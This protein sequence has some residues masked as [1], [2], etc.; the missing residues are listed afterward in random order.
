MGNVL[1]DF[2]TYPTILRLLAE[3]NR[4]LRAATEELGT[5]AERLCDDL[6]TARGMPPRLHGGR[7]DADRR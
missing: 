1:Y 4:R 7:T 2:Q 6:R 5:E 3:E